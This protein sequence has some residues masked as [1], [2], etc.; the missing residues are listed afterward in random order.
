MNGRPLERD[1]R[2]ENGDGPRGEA[3][4]PKIELP[5]GE[6]EPL[7]RETLRCIDRIHGATGLPRLSV[8]GTQTSPSYGRYHPPTETE[9]AHIEILATGPTPRITFLHEMGHLWDHFLGGFSEFASHNAAS[10]LGPVVEALKQTN[11]YARLDEAAHRHETR[12]RQRVYVSEYLL[13]NHELWARAYAQY[14]ATRSN[15]ATLLEEIDRVRAEPDY[16]QYRQWSGEDFSDVADAID[17]A[18]QKI[19]WRR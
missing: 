11:A 4:A 16:D 14:I 18:L 9:A 2:G 5:P 1:E 3:V 10:P 19:G 7:I 6:L 8:I 17:S 12:L 15:D 13:S